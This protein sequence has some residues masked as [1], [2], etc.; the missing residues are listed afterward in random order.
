VVT[1]RG[2]GVV[3]EVRW[4]KSAGFALGKEVD[5]LPFRLEH[6]SKR[7]ILM[8]SAEYENVEDVRYIAGVYLGNKSDLRSILAVTGNLH[9][10]SGSALGAAWDAARVPTAWPSTPL[11]CSC[12]IRGSRARSQLAAELR[13]TPL[14]C[15]VRE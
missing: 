10:E 1:H 6:G 11:W 15:A 12:R 7:E 4:R 2:L 3:V 14:S 5:N 9:V 8:N 13:S